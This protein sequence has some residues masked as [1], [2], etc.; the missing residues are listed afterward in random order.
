MTHPTERTLYEYICD[1]FRQR[2]WSCSTETRT[3]RGDQEPDILLEK[4]GMLIVSEVK[5]DSEIKLSDAIADAYEKS[6]TLRTNNYMA[7]LFH[8][9]IRDIPP[10]MLELKYKD[11]EIATTLVMTEWLAERQ[12]NLTLSKFA[13]LITERLE[14]Y[15]QTKRRL[16]SYDLVVGVAQEAI[17]DIAVLLRLHIRMGKVFDTS[18]TA[19]GRFDLYTSLMQGEKI[20]KDETK[21]YIADIVSFI[22]VNQL[23]FYQIVSAKTGRYT[24]L[25]SVHPLQP[26]QDLLQ[27]LRSQ[28]SPARSDYPEILGIDVFEPLIESK[29]QRILYALSRIVYVIRTLRPQDIQE[30]LF[31]RL[32][33]ETIPFE[34]RKNLG[35]FYTNPDAARLL[36]A[37]A[38]ERW[39][40]KVIDPACGSGTLLV[41]AY[42]RK[43]SLAPVSMTREK[44][45]SLFVGKH[46]YGIDAMQFAVHTAS[47]NLLS[48]L[49]ELNV[50]PN[51]FQQD[52][53]ISLVRKGESKEPD[54]K[55]EIDKWWQ[56]D[57]VTIPRDF[58]TVIMNPPFTRRDR[59]PTDYRDDL[60]KIMP[61]VTGKTGL[62]AYF[63]VG[64]K[65]V[66]KHKQSTI[67]AVTPEEFFV[68]S[69]AL[70]VRR[71]LI[72]AG[73][74]PNIIVRS[75]AQVA[76]SE[77]AHYRDYLVRFDRSETGH[78]IIL[79]LKVPVFKIRERMDEILEAIKTL[80]SQK[81]RTC[82]TTDEF[83]A[84]RLDSSES[85]LRRHIENLKP[86]VGFNT[87]RT[88]LMALRILSTLSDFPK[89]GDA[90]PIRLYR[91]GQITKKGV[92]ETCE[93]L[94]LSRYGARSA[95]AMFRMVE[96]K[97]PSLFITLRNRSLY[98]YPLPRKALVQSLRTYSEVTH[99]DITGREEFAVA[100]AKAISNDLM[101]I[102][103]LVKERVVTAAEDIA[104][105]HERFASHLLLSR[106][107]RLSSP[108]AHW[109]AFY[110][111]NRV[112]GSQ[113]PN[114][115][116]KNK[117][118]AKALA[119]Y[120]NSTIAMI[121]LLAFTAETEGA[122]VSL[123]H[124]KVWGQVHVPKIL[125]SKNESSLDELLKKAESKRS[126]LER[127]KGKDQ[128]QEQID[129]FSLEMLGL[130]EE[131]SLVDLRSAVANELGLLQAVA[132][133]VPP[134]KQRLIG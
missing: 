94:F 85:L 38:I 100:D 130:K 108:H 127:L 35:A 36:A 57:N 95:N 66:T 116:V 123:D 8:Q 50:K 53:I 118:D 47:I 109:V 84:L 71:S 119:L 40:S 37:L 34:T 9:N 11:V 23:L 44:L 63:F 3:A 67:A 113:L 106:R 5:I 87:P 4:N 134:S 125:P 56:K 107:V 93:K 22:L 111:D 42:R 65:E 86:L 78:L 41:E 79:F 76:F 20:T 19:I 114:V 58:D 105:A 81:D 16:V 31:G 28:F 68:G 129:E 12:R 99:L 15:E 101:R 25:P 102:S 121:Q 69:S 128:L 21:L 88:Q 54:D 59:I 132:A 24:P 18:L 98:Q 17:K 49:I 103:G 13:D 70:S 131:I 104:E 39:D 27:T 92:E 120:L 1:V 82:V 45:H 75:V 122:Y 133:Q 74:M 32:Y 61:D 60:A 29:D 80:R 83:E 96:S 110:S 7:M 2:G 91:P 124:K 6:L 46:I 43:A 30:D 26:P 115:S 10:Q 90:H 55:N 72:D 51:I 33:Q 112:L 89:L 48:N 14:R 64:A 52:G 62:W 77:S 117:T 73:F 126:I 97:S